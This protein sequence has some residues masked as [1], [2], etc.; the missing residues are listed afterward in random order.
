MGTYSLEILRWWLLVE[1]PNNY[2][3]VL[4]FFNEPGG[5]KDNLLDIHEAFCI[6]NFTDMQWGSHALEFDSSPT[7]SLKVER[8]SYK[9]KSCAE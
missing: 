6:T 4:L 2:I 1:C 8:K 7:W 9:K 3:C 5:Y